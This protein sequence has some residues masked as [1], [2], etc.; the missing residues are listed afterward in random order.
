MNFTIKKGVDI[1]LHTLLDPA[2][3]PQNEILSLPRFPRGLRMAIFFLIKTKHYQPEE[4][5]GQA[6]DPFNNIV[7]PVYDFPKPCVKS[8]GVVC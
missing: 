5:T 6:Q 4:P 2:V 8:W 1:L 7:D 3:K